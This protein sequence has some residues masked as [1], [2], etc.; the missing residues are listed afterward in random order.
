MR[1][2]GITIP[3]SK[4]LEIGLTSIYGIGR[5]MALRILAEASV[6]PGK[7]ADD[8]STEQ[9]NKI[10]SAIEDRGLLIEGELRR[11]VGGHIKRLKDI[12]SYRGSRHTKR[13]PCRGQH[14]K[15]NARTLKGVRKTMGSGRR[16]VE[17]K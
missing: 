13:L 3:N 2:A 15:T 7:T 11:E 4:R 8:L 16:T 6:E 1:I 9:E 12:S 5:P 10:R 17:K 14:T